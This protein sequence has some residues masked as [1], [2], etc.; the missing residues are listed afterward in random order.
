MESEN[1]VKFSLSANG[2]GDI[3][4]EK[5]TNIDSNVSEVFSKSMLFPLT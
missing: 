4:T 5:I 2:N 1:K 3:F